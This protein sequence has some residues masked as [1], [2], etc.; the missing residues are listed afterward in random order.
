[1]PNS[2]DYDPSPRAGRKYAGT[3][4]VASGLVADMKRYLLG[5]RLDYGVATFNGWYPSNQAGDTLPRI[6]IPGIMTVRGPFWQART[7]VGGEPRYQSPGGERNGAVIV[8]RPYAATDRAVVVEGPMDALVAAMGSEVTH[9]V[10]PGGGSH[11]MGG[12]LGIAVMGNNP[13]MATLETVARQCIHLGIRSILFVPDLDS[14]G[15]FAV[16]L[17]VLAAGGFRCE[18]RIPPQKDLAACDDGQRKDVLR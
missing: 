6:V 11:R 8:V 17:G 16:A 1:M 10:T 2:Y 14:P 7:L 13:G 4:P 15:A 5:R 3:P 12:Q 18:M 9:V